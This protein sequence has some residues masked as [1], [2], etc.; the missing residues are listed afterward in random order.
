MKVRNKITGEINI[1]K[2]DECYFEIYKDDGEY[3]CPVSLKQLND[4]WED[5]EE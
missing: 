4:G 1:I 2:V 5:Y 3:V